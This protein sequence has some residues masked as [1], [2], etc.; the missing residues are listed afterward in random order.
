VTL[1]LSA[2]RA[3]YDRWRIKFENLS[4]P[5]FPLYVILLTIG[6]IDWIGRSTSPGTRRSG[7]AVP[8][9]TGLSVLALGILTVILCVV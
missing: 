2:A 6:A 9:C 1:T 5:A 8:G 7:A 3:D 4:G